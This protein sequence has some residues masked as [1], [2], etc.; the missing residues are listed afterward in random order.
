MFVGLRRPPRT[1]LSETFPE[2]PWS[3]V[4][5]SLFAEYWISYS[6]SLDVM[7]AAWDEG[8]LRITEKDPLPLGGL[9]RCIE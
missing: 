5:N 6:L 1:F 7:V 8:E 9:Q 2:I 3:I 4:A